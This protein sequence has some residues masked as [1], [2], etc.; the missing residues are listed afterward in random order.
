MTDTLD[1]DHAQVVLAL[2]AANPNI[3]HV[4]DGAVSNPTPDPPYVLVY[5]SVSRPFGAPSNGLD[6]ASKTVVTRVKCKCVGLNAALARAVGMQV[7]AALIDQRPV[8]AGRNCGPIH[9]DDAPAPP[10]R[11]ESTGRL[12]M[13]QDLD[14]MFTSTG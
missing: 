4:F 10:D 2:L 8:I 9:E 1:E 5:T 12:L 13:V 14:Y 6:A 3:A 11:D 7:R